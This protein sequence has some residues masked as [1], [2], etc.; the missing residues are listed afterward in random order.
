MM[1]PSYTFRSFLLTLVLLGLGR[2]L[3]AQV[4]WNGELQEA[5]FHFQARLGDCVAQKDTALLKELLYER[6]Y[7]CWDAFDCAGVEGCPKDDFVRILFADSNSREW[8]TLGLLLQTGFQAQLDTFE[9]PFL[10]DSA[11]SR[12]YV[13]PPYTLAVGTLH[14]L[15]DETPLYSHPDLHAI[16]SKRLKSGVYTCRTDKQGRVQIINDQWV[17]LHDPNSDKDLYVEVKHSSF[18]I[19]RELRVLRINGAWKIVAFL[20]QMDV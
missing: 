9:Y 5:F 19:D 16:T 13:A 6:V 3:P 1:N 8:H 2:P 11:D 18:A 15:H 17:A 14:I 4:E 20:C 10:T 7:E 12:S